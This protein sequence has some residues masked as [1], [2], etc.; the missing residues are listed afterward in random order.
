MYSGVKI[1]SNEWG[2]FI[3]KGFLNHLFSFVLYLGRVLFIVV[4][5]M[6]IHFSD[7]ISERYWLTLFN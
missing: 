1:T 6:Y 7:S 3:A 4:E 2:A 5:K